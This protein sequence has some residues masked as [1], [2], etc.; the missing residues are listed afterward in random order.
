MKNKKNHKEN[1]RKEGIIDLIEYTLKLKLNLYLIRKK[2]G[3]FNR[4]MT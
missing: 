4:K 2:T 1:K 3:H